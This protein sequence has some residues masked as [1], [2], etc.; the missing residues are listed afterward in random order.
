M[1]G[2]RS[3]DADAMRAGYSDGGQEPFPVKRAKLTET[4]CFAT[5]ELSGSGAR[6]SLE[7]TVLE[8]LVANCPTCHRAV[9]RYYDRWLRDNHRQD[10]ADAPEA[11]E[12][13]FQ[14]RQTYRGQPDAAG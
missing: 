14:A 4:P 11:R 2:F 5:N 3:S 13:Y 8:D 10:F 12:V 9:H 7:G 6:T 1:I